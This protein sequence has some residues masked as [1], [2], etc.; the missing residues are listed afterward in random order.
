VQQATYEHDFLQEDEY[1]KFDFLELESL[2]VKGG[3]VTAEEAIT[4][5]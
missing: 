3:Y 2:L 1:L 5:P 4:G